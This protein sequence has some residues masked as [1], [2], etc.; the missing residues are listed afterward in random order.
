MQR[1]QIDA[2]AAISSHSQPS[3]WQQTAT[4]TQRQ[5]DRDGWIDGRPHMQ[6]CLL[7]NSRWRVDTLGSSLETSVMLA[8]N[9]HAFQ[10]GCPQPVTVGYWGQSTRPETCQHTFLSLV[11]LDFTRCPSRLHCYCVCVCVRQGIRTLHFDSD[12]QKVHLKG[13]WCCPLYN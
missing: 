4:V 6:T 10:V 3:E 12:L 9:L 7:I 13:V 1:L 8:I 5:A 2:S 11:R